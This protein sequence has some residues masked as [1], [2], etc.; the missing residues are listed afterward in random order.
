VVVLKCFNG[1]LFDLYTRKCCNAPLISLRHKFFDWLI[2]W[3]IE[4]VINRWR[5]IIPSW[6]NIIAGCGRTIDRLAS[7]DDFVP[8]CPSV[9]RNTDVIYLADF[10][11]LVVLYVVG[12]LLEV[13][14]L[15]WC[16]TIIKSAIC[17][18]RVLVDGYN[19]RAKWVKYVIW[20]ILSFVTNNR[21]F[22]NAD[23]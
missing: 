3:L 13:V 2:D 16:Y 20:P 8:C 17:C 4:C 5:Q 21:S 23:L 14:V 15:R 7:S 18:W 9:H 22:A 6:M 10:L 19:R 1:F 11:Q 12:V